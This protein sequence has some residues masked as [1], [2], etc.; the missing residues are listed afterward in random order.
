MFNMAAR[1][2]SR[3]KP[4]D[5]TGWN[6]ATD[7]LG[8]TT[9]ALPIYIHH[10]LI[11]PPK[12]TVQVIPLTRSR[13]IYRQFCPR[14]ALYS[15]Y[16]PN[17]FHFVH[18]CCKLLFHRHEMLPFHQR[19]RLTQQRDIDKPSWEASHSQFLKL[20]CGHAFETCADALLCKCVT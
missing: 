12:L 18:E 2:N 5:I 7:I 8:D 16:L 14:Q 9:G 10:H 20:D 11:W 13:L 19:W 15:L 17:N 3:Q 6:D 4:M 1:E